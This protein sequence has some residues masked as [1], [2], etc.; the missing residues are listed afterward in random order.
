MLCPRTKILEHTIFKLIYELLEKSNLIDC[1]QHGFRKRK[2][3]VTA[4]LETVHD[5]A[6]V[7]DA[8]SQMPFFRLSKRV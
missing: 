8:Q 7:I 3:T 2:S 4:L 1:R 6:A 5:S